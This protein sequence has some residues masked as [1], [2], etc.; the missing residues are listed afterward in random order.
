MLTNLIITSITAKGYSKDEGFLAAKFT[1]EVCEIQ[2]G[3][4][5]VFIPS[6]GRNNSQ[7]GREQMQSEICGRGREGMSG[8]PGK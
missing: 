7:K 6:P 8:Q 1:K 3:L 4:N 2:E 5:L